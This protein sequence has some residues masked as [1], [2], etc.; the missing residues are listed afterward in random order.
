MALT[1][2]FLSALGIEA[3]KVDQI[4][5][6][7]T[8]T[9]DGLKEELAKVKADADKLPAVTKERDDLKAAAEK[10]GKD[11]YRVKYE[12]IR[13]EFAE[14][15]KE[16][17]AKATKAAKS[18][19][20]RALLKEA[21]VRKDSLIDSIL[22]IVDL[23]GIELDEKGKIVDATKL[24]KGIQD[25]WADFIGKESV[26]GANTPNPP[27]NNGGSGAMTRDQIYERDESGRF[28]LDATQRQAALSQLIAQEAQKG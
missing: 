10:D 25:E 7:H 8:E 2:K 6:A 23:D 28:K 9:I 22:K 27:A 17:E 16:I 5:D 11:P 3:D 19:A 15:K 26:Q 21:G 4:I 20:Y 24:K 18:D 13:E 12:A 1:R 14:Y